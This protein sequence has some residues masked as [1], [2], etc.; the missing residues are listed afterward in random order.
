MPFRK[1]LS[2]SGSSQRHGDAG[3]AFFH[4]RFTLAATVLSRGG[5]NLRHVL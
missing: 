3:N 5:P 1:T 4:A 2:L